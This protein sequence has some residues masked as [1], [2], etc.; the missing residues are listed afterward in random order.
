VVIVG[1]N[2]GNGIEPTAAADREVKY[3]GSKVRAQD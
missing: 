2:H 3:S 1:A